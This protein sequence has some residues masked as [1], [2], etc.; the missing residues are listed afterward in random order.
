MFRIAVLAFLVASASAFAPKFAPRA[1]RNVR[2]N[3]EITKG[4]EVSTPFLVL[5]F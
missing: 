4:V 1:L 3:V 2:A 5:K